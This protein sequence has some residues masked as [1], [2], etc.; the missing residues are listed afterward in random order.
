M[1][2]CRSDD[3]CL[4]LYTTIDDYIATFG[5][6]LGE[7]VVLTREQALE[8]ADEMCEWHEERDEDG[9]IVLNHCGYVERD[10]VEF[11]DVVA[12]VLGHA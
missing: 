12:R 2:I 4:E 1:R 8:I 5:Y 9:N 10:D 3:D 6:D 7:G 11:W